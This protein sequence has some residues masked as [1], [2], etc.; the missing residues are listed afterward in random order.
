[1]PMQRR[2]GA[3][4]VEDSPFL[5]GIAITNYVLGALDLGSTIWA[6]YQPPKEKQKVRLSPLIF[7]DAHGRPA[8]GVGLR[9]VDW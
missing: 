1:M 4:D 6:I 2:M 7:P 3:I 8:V 5:L 9:V